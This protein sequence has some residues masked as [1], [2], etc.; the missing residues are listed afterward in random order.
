MSSRDDTAM[1]G[2]MPRGRKPAAETTAGARAQTA[3]QTGAEGALAPVRA[4][5]LRRARDQA[6]GITAAAG[7][8]AASA[9]SQAHREAAGLAARG[10]EAGRAQA[11]ALAAQLLAQ[12]RRDARATVLGTQREAHEELRRRV[13]A[14]V[15]ALRDEPGY[16]LLLERL[17]R[18]AAQAAG[19]H[20]VLTEAPAGGIIARA[21]G[22]IVDCS[23]PRLADASVE[24]LGD[25]VAWLW[26]PGER[27]RQR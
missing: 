26:T 20:A 3:A 23:L 11:A 5:L 16:D 1:T 18:E 25:Q 6:A 19:P 27:R 13:R 7:A 21:P 22:I 14:T 8:Q 17:R 9:R 15:A 24:A 10:R 2:I 12:G 4:A